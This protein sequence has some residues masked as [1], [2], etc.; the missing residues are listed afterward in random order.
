LDTISKL[1]FGAANGGN[2]AQRHSQTKSKRRQKSGKRKDSTS[3]TQAKLKKLKEA[4]T[5]RLGLKSQPNQPGRSSPGGSLDFSHDTA[6][7]RLSVAE[8][9]APSLNH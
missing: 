7:K 6:G 2:M 9:G 1:M 5:V 8:S 4:E 3:I